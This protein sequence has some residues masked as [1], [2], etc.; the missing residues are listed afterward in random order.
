VLAARLSGV[1]PKLVLTRHLAKSPGSPASRRYLLACC[2]LLVAVSE[3]TAKILRDGSFE[4]DAIEEERRRRLPMRGDHSKI[5]V[6]HGGIDTDQF[7]PF[8]ASALRAGWG[9]E[10][11]HFAFAVVGGYGPPRG[12][13]QREFLQAAAAAHKEIPDAR[14]LIIG[15]GGLKGVLE[16]DIV[17]LGLEGKAWLTPY[18]HDMPSAM[19]AIDCLVHPAIGTESFG[20]VVCEAFSCG[21]P[22][23]AAS[24]D[25]IPEAFAMGGF[26]Q[27]FKPESVGE[28]GGLMRTWAVR[29]RPGMPER[30]RLWRQI[31]EK[32]GL[33]RMAGEIER[34]YLGLL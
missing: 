20:L 6:V 25:G 22:A 10:P 11:N 2:D 16:D 26:G 28:M 17:R 30:E 12:K 32:C 1:R 13:G 33:D 34:L 14:F 5:K 18:C 21:K 7:R 23:L 31:A 4:P 19:N 9:L 3:A 15:R 24:L 27:L 29:P 8:D